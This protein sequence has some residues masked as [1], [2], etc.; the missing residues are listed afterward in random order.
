MLCS[1]MLRLQL[2]ACGDVMYPDIVMTVCSLLVILCSL[3]L[4]RQIVATGDVMLLDDEMAVG[5]YW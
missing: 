1:L 5:R 3:R 2:V 4:K